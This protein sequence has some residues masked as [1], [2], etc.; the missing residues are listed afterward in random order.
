MTGLTGLTG[1]TVLLLVS[2]CASSSTQDDKEALEV[3][4]VQYPSSTI[5]AS[6]G[7]SLRLPCRVFYDE[8]QCD[9]LRAAWYQL[10]SPPEPAEQLSEP[11]RYGTTVNE[12]QS[13]DGR[14]HRAVLT[15]I[16]RVT[17][18]DEG[19]FQCMAECEGGEQV[20]GHIIYVTVGGSRDAS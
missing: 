4:E 3:L 7:S 16:L 17:P 14:R 5:S 1:P 12:T 2:F 19:A 15:E 6:I 10:G 8:K 13:E 11:G 18:Q 20:M 9:L